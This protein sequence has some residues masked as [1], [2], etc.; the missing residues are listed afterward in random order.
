MHRPFFM[1][2]G[3]WLQPERFD[4]GNRELPADV[5]PGGPG[6]ENVVYTLVSRLRSGEFVGR[7]P[8]L[9]RR[10]GRM[11]RVLE[12]THHA[13]D[14]LRRQARAL[15]PADISPTLMPAA[16]RA[17]ESAGESLRGHLCQVFSDEMSRAVAAERARDVAQYDCVK[18]ANGTKGNRMVPGEGWL[19][20]SHIEAREREQ[21]VQ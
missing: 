8:E 1:G 14:Q 19:C 5:S 6:G 9:G 11:V 15:L 16:E 13:S 12:A 4:M 3:L 18:C 7:Y 21:S 2:C 20:R 10:C 17:I